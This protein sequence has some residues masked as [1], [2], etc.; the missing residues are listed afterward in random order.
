MVL[1]GKETDKSMPDNIVSYKTARD[2]GNSLIECCSYNPWVWVCA[3]KWKQVMVDPSLCDCS[4]EKKLSF[5]MSKDVG[6]ELHIAGF[7]L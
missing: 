7:H 4:A 1:R 5:Y 2:I 6:H 3:Q